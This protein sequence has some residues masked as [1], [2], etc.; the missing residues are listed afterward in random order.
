[1]TA[2]ACAMPNDAS[3]PATN[4]VGSTNRL[5]SLFLDFMFYSLENWLS[6]KAM[7]NNG[8]GR[9]R[10][11]QWRTFV[12]LWAVMTLATTTLGLVTV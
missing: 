5:N 9:R 7:D 8:T 1:M 6:R 3:A 10:F 12:P 4:T 11:C 2:D